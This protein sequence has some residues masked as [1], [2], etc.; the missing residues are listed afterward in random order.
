M[1]QKLVNIFSSVA[2]NQP[3]NKNFE[4]TIGGK[5]TDNLFYGLQA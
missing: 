2:Y 1:P 5:G 4:L 3:K